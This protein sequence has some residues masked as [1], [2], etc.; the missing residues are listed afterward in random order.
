MVCPSKATG[1]GLDLGLLI[2]GAVLTETAYSLPGLGKFAID[3]INHQDL[4]KVMGVVT[5]AAFFVVFANLVVDLV[6]GLV[7]PRVRIG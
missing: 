1:F 3:A 2:G 5:V 7:D 4:P 6:Y